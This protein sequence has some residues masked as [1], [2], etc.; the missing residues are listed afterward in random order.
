[1]S[2]SHALVFDQSDGAHHRA[3]EIALPVDLSSIRGLPI[4]EHDNVQAVGIGWHEAGPDLVPWQC[5]VSG[6]H[7]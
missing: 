2:Q 7:M 6:D 1:M 3:I 5:S 4:I